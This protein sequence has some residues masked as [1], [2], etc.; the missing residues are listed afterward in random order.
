MAT[1]SNV[2]AWRIPGTGEP[3]GLPSM[4]SHR[5]RHDWSDLAAAA[6]SFIISW[7]PKHFLTCLCL[8]YAPLEHAVYEGRDF[9][10]FY[11]PTGFPPSRKFWARNK[12]SAHFWWQWVNE[13]VTERLTVWV[14]SIFP[15]PLQV[16]LMAHSWS[17]LQLFLLIWSFTPLN[18]WHFHISIRENFVIDINACDWCRL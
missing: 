10:L 1:H 4:G 6:A 18:L 2:L 8:S 7:H 3:G 12:H 17:C 11:F 9:H 15:G 14:S 13:W 16:T 5:V